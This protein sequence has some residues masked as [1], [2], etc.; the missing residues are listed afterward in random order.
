MHPLALGLARAVEVLEKGFD[1]REGLG[2]G[3]DA[4]LVLEDFG[5]VLVVGDGELGPGL[6]EGGGLLG[7][8][9]LEL[10]LDVPG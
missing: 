4:L 7:G 9:A 8:A 2:G 1:S 10:C 5:H 6:E 3:E